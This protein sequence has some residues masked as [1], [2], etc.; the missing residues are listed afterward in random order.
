MRPERKGLA[1]VAT[2]DALNA[3]HEDELA[4]RIESADAIMMYHNLAL[5]RKTIRRLKHCRLIVR[6]GVGVDNVDH[7][8][9]AT[10]G[11][12][13]AN[14]PDYGGTEDVADTAIGMLLALTRGTHYLNSRLRQKEGPWFYSQVVP[15]RR[16]R[17][18]V[19]G[20]VGVGTNRQRG[21][22]AGEGVGDG[23]RV[24]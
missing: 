18:Q 16:L 14:I 23:S 17:G 21:G 12:P 11:I 19:C 15:L 24:L 1:R 10:R 5:T 2:V 22:V 20:I 7:A 13:V 6:C 9:A 3:M 4:G 8:F